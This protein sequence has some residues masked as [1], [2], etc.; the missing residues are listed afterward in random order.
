MTI[1]QDQ[2]SAIPAGLRALKQWVCWR[3][4]QR[5]EGKPTKQPM[6]PNGLPATHS[7]PATW[8]SFDEVC[9]AAGKFDGI[10]FVFTEADPYCGIDLDGCFTMDGTLKEWAVEAVMAAQEAECY[11]ERTPS[12][13]GL[14]IIGRAVFGSGR[15][16]DHGQGGVEVYDRQRYFTVTGEQT[17]TGDVDNSLSA[18][19][20]VLMRKYFP[21]Q[22][23]GAPVPAGDV[24]PDHEADQ[25]ATRC[26]QG[27]ASDFLSFWHD[28]IDVQ[29]HGGDR[30]AHRLSLLTKVALKLW[31]L[32]GRQP[33]ANELRAV[34]LR[35]PFIKHEMSSM[36]GKWPRLAKTECP[37]AISYAA[38][39]RV[40]APVAAPVAVLASAG[41]AGTAPGEIGSD[42]S[43]D[44]SAA[45]FA[46][47]AEAPDY[48][49]ENIIR[50]GYLYALTGM[51]NAGKT[52]I[53]LSLVEAANLGVP[54]AGNETTRCNCL[55][56]AG[57]NATDVQFRLIAM[58][59]E[60]GCSVADILPN[61]TIVPY[62]FAIEQGL[63][64]LRKLA[65]KKGGFGIVLVDSK[66]AYFGG[67]K[68][69]D[70]AQAYA[71]ARLF[72]DLTQIEGKPA[73]IVL[74]HPTKRPSSQEDL[75]PRGGS[76][77]LNEIDTNLT[78]WK[79]TGADVVQLWHT[80]IR[81]FSFEPIQVQIKVVHLDNYTTKRG[82]K[83][84]S[85]VA[86]PATSGDA[87]KAVAR[88]RIDENRLLMAIVENPGATQRDWAKQCGWVNSTGAPQT[89]RM[90]RVIGR[91]KTD[92]LIK[93]NRGTGPWLLTQ[94]GTAEVKK[95][96]NEP[97]FGVGSEADLGG[98]NDA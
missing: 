83:I 36:R 23:Q 15:K 55:M 61:L 64:F 14:H 86:V 76:S 78:A 5:G 26:L 22:D 37:M 54:F 71:Q 39:N 75:M 31:A 7:D 67:D 56:L 52:S 34:A 19:V 90:T 49:I 87:E 48:I 51:S 41:V 97:G 62:S 9:A 11:I 53:G 85:V 88:A 17:V 30:S 4:V 12:G 8:S 81:G 21:A 25:H 20:S 77:F 32:L 59:Q 79:E 92:K 6:Q 28:K 42:A 46:A 91:L 10:G 35:A 16:K 47:L 65:Q 66:T 27:A 18:A 38:K 57:E 80:K 33:T 2:L 98:Q 3:L 44:V 60:E 45:D 69:D 1:A 63:E 89:S 40:E 43:Y 96:G 74:C 70:N 29:K 50:R 73:V 93:Q 94:K 82:K 58:A 95:L 24:I 68:E 84:T 72:R 13:L